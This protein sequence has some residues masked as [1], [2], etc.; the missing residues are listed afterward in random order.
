VLVRGGARAELERA[1]GRVIV[2]IQ[3]AQVVPRVL[4]VQIGD[5]AIGRHAAR[6]GVARRVET[7]ARA[8]RLLLGRR[9]RR[10]AHALLLQLEAP[11]VAVA[12]VALQRAELGRDLPI[13]HGLDTCPL[14]RDPEVVEA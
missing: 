14:V 2:R 7:K 11:L 8:G 10:D 5:R 1:D 6:H 9:A 3:L 13:A 4:R 12:A